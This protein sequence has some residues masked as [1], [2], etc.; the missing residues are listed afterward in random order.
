M[1]RKTVNRK[2]LGAVKI[3]GATMIIAVL[4]AALFYIYFYG[5]PANLSTVGIPGQPT[6]T[7]TLTTPAGFVNYK[8][9]FLYQEQLATTGGSITTTSPSYRVFNS[10][11]QRLSAL[12]T[13]YGAA[14]TTIA[15]GTT[16]TGVDVKQTDNGYMF[17]SLNTGTTDFPDPALILSNNPAFTSCKWIPVATTSTNTL[18]CELE[19]AK[20]GQ[21]NYQAGTNAISTT[22]KIQANLDDLSV[23]ASSPADQDSMGI[24]AGTDVYVT[25]TL[26][27]LTA[28]NAFSIAKISYTSNQT[29]A[30]MALFD[31][32]I[33]PAT[34]IVN[35]KTSTASSV[36]TFNSASK[37]ATST[38][39]VT[40]YWQYIPT[41]ATDA[42]DYSDTYMVAR[43]TEADTIDVRLHAKV[44][45]PAATDAVTLVISVI[46]MSAANAQQS[47]V[48]DS[49][50]IGG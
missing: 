7:S 3:T 22:L 30:Y 27:G 24:V 38:S 20:L 10:N 47:A 34:K 40:Q 37:T 26:S 46:L 14:S 17:V 39:G 12:N 35:M 9:G 2:Q 1:T 25:W 49:V 21:P 19:L 4:A 31:M 36:L 43:S 33:T 15:S 6:T 13:L 32:S 42:L 29:S 45:F 50:I 23:T 5:V 48:T 8:V 28:T 18:V 44:S 41:T 16:A 11:G